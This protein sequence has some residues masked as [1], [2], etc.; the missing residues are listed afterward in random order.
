MRLSSLEENPLVSI[1]I[2]SYNYG[3][4]L[5]TAL[6]SLRSQTYGFFEVI[7]CD[8]GSDDDSVPCVERYSRLDDRFRL[9]TQANSGQ[10]V[11]LNAAFAASTG[12]LVSLLDADDFFEPTK[13]ERVVSLI[14]IEEAGCILH[15]L[16]IVDRDG[17]VTGRIP[18]MGRVEQGWFAERAIRRGGRWRFLPTT[19]LTFRREIGEVI[20]PIPP[21]LRAYADAFVFTLLPLLTTV[22]Y[23][24]VPLAAYRLHGQNVTSRRDNMLDGVRRNAGTWVQIIDMVNERL[25]TMEWGDQEVQLDVNRNL[26]YR[27]RLFVVDLL[28]GQRSRLDLTSRLIALAG[29]VARDDIYSV[30]QRVALILLSG[31]AIILPRQLRAA[32]LEWGWSVAPAVKRFLSRI[33]NLRP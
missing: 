17:K 23:V 10:A 25:R 4:Y 5:E 30:A 20:F 14:R 15:P 12:S 26:E 9:L 22:D 31:M 28:G 18:V 13:L 2:S 3:R 24:D 1:L 29:L 21:Q 27:H 6:E 32:W 7:V 16:N 19:A 33:H 8:D 11:A